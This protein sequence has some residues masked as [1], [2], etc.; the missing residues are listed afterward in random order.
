MKKV[1]NITSNKLYNPQNKKPAIPID[2]DE[3]DSALE[4]F[5]R[6]KYMNQGLGTMRSH[7]TGSTGSDETPPP[8]PPKSTGK[9]SLRAASSTFPLFGKKKDRTSRSAHSSP[10]IPPESPDSGHRPKVSKVFGA[11]LGYDSE[12]DTQK[13]L[14]KLRE[15]GFS[16]D[17]RNEAI[18]KGVNGNLERTIETLVRIEGRSP[19]T[20]PSD[21][22]PSVS[23]PMGLT[24]ARAETARPHTTSS[25]NPF[26]MSPVQPMSAQSTGNLGGRNPFFN[27]NNNPFGL[28][29]TQSNDAMNQAFNN[30]SLST[31]QQQPQPLFPHH[32][33]GLPNQQAQQVIYQQSM[34]APAPSMP[35]HYAGTAFNSNSPYRQQELQ[36]AQSLQPAHTGYNP[37]LNN[38]PTAQP[39]PQYGQPM[40]LNTATGGY[41]NNPFLRSP[42]RIASPTSLGQIPEQTQ[43]NFYSTPVQQQ[44][45]QQQQQYQQPQQPQQ[46]QQQQYQQYQQQQQQQQ[47]PQQYQQQ[48]QTAQT[49]NPF[50]TQ[51]SATP[52]APQQSLYDQFG[53]PMMQ[54]APQRPDKAAILALY[55][56]PQLAPQPVQNGTSEQQQQQ[57][58]QPQQ[59]QQRQLPQTEQA[60]AFQ[61]PSS[62]GTMPGG[63]SSAAA[64]TTP[65]TKNPFLSGAA[66]PQPVSAPAAGVDGAI[67]N[68]SRDSMMA[69]GMEWSNG[70]HSPDA[71]ASLS[72]RSMR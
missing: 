66:I 7:N 65:G 20:S 24:V 31:P 59:Q 12:D 71:F 54:Q 41:A 25:S 17:R 63:Y 55:N 45:Q 6:S 68:R 35:H 69:L 3:V 61:A 44:P 28:T 18:L 29:A 30:M 27:N 64:T 43:Q 49:N 50:M 47:Q 70:R 37:F 16:D 48:P 8:I 52:Y 67:G 4:R 33:G 42:S 39:Q 38:T 22:F 21:E 10:H 5:I 46:Q 58:Q 13:K 14:A 9:F 23:N 40:S 2:A 1:G 36:P 32:T 51:P 72:A 15:L 19:V 11:S 53:Q 60:Q 57:D 56:Y 26:D 62:M 34:N